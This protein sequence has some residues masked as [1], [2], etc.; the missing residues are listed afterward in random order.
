[1]LSKRC[2]FTSKN[3]HSQLNGRFYIKTNIIGF[4][5]PSLGLRNMFH[6]GFWLHWVIS[7]SACLPKPVSSDPSR[8]LQAPTTIVA[9]ARPAVRTSSFSNKEQGPHPD[10]TGWRLRPYK[11]YFRYT[12]ITQTKV[13]SCSQ[14]ASFMSK[15]TPGSRCPN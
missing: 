14:R 15:P 6:Q 9:S 7:L 12:R 2:R 8:P 11:R 4:Y 10:A 3:T 13:E 5:H 1:M